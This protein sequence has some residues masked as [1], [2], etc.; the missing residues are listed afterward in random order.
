M[1]ARADA[2]RGELVPRVGE[3]HLGRRRLDHEPERV[4]K[5]EPQQ[6]PGEPVGQRRQAHCPSTNRGKGPHAHGPPTSR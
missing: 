3:R 6:R 4:A 1:G 2:R 5:R